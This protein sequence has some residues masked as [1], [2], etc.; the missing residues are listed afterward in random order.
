MQLSHSVEHITT[1]L[2][3]SW[4]S[5]LF[6]RKETVDI[7]APLYCSIAPYFTIISGQDTAQ[8]ALNMAEKIQQ[9]VTPCISLCQPIIWT[10]QP[11]FSSFTNRSFTKLSSLSVSFTN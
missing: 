11:P 1:F 9:L 7:I 10:L 3:H 6:A 5:S 2:T 4:C 8:A